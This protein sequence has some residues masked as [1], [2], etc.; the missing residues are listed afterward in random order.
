MTN[1]ATNLFDELQWRGMVYD[2]TE[3]LRDLLATERKVSAIWSAIQRATEEGDWRPNPGRLC[4][5]CDH[6]SLCPA[7]GGT[8]PE[9]PVLAVPTLPEARAADERPSPHSPADE[10]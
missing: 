4:D 5:W 9:L 2:A 6:Q 7:Y 3:G 10:V 1:P 8:P